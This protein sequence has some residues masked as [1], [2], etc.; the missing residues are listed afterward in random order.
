M[1]R[2]AFVEDVHDGLPASYD[3]KPPS[4]GLLSTTFVVE[5]PP[6]GFIRVPILFALT[7]GLD[8]FVQR[9]QQIVDDFHATGNRTSS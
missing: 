6:A 7:E 4:V 5:N 2:A 8:L 1:T 9:F 3:P